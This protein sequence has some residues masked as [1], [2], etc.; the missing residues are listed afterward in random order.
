MYLWKRKETGREEKR[1]TKKVRKKMDDMCRNKVES[2]GESV[3][4]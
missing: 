2:A 4:E 1:L 3:R